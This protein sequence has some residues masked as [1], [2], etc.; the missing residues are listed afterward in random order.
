LAEQRAYYSSLAPDYLDQGLDLPGGDELTDALDAFRPEG[1][2][3]T[4]SSPAVPGTWTPQ[5]LRHAA[6][7]HRQLMRPRR[8][9]RD[10]GEP[11]PGRAPPVEIVEADLFNWEPDRTL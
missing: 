9:L 10:R 11:R 7:V 3:S 6:D 5:L 4:W 2:A 8:M 1:K